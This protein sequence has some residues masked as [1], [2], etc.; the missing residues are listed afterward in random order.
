[1]IH[2]EKKDD[3]FTIIPNSL[4]KNRNISAAAKGLMVMILALP[5]DWDFNMQGLVYISGMSMYSLKKIVKELETKGYIKRRK[6]HK[7]GTFVWEYLIYENQSIENQ[8]IENQSIE[9][10][11]IENQSIENQSIENSAIYKELNKQRTNIQST[12][13]L[14]TDRVGEKRK[15]FTPPTKEEVADYCAEKKLSIDTERFIDFYESKGW[16]VG[17]NKM[18]DWKASVRNWARSESVPAQ[19][20]TN[21]KKSINDDIMAA[22]EQVKREMEGK[23]DSG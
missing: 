21:H 10:Q 5:D 4:I 3:N 8:S 1:M 14:I 16:M 9:N 20:N 23:Y 15:R 12:N 2:R 13:I 18:K 17:K 7:G 6:V 22:V 19:R 11:S